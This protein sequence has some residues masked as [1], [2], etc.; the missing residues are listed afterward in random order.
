[1]TGRRISTHLYDPRR[2][3]EA[4]RLSEC[5]VGREAV[6]PPRSN[7]FSIYWIAAGDGEFWADAARHA[8]AG[9]ALLFFKPY[10]YVRVVA[11][12]AADAA[13]IQ[14]H[15]NFLCVET[16]HAESGCAGELFNDSYAAPVVQ[17]G[18]GV[19]GIV[20]RMQ[21]E[22]AARPLAFEEV[23]ASTQPTLDFYT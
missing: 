4:I 17:V 18:R 1:M 14:F 16:F 19:T 11:E 21:R 13:V 7:C 2:D 15:A 5:R 3:G 10:Q 8:F 22:F 9:P 6:E 23:G 12:A 20:R